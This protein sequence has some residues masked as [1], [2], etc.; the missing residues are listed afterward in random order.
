MVPDALRKRLWLGVGVAA[1]AAAAAATPFGSSVDAAGAAAAR[2]LAVTGMP[3]DTSGFS[4]S[5]GAE[6][7]GTSVAGR[8]SKAEAI[9]AVTR[10]GLRDVSPTYP[11]WKVLCG[12][13]AGTGSRTMVASISGLDNVGML[14]WA[15]FRWSGS[16]WQFLMKQRHAAVLTADASDIRETWSIYRESDSRCCPSGGT[17]SRIWHW[18]GNRF[19]ASP[20][21]QATPGTGTDPAG[22][23]GHFKSPSGNI[24]CEYFLDWENRNGGRQALIICAIRSGLKPKPPYTPQ[25]AAAGLDHN[26]DRINL[27]ATGRALPVVCSG[28]AGPFI[29]ERDARVL[30]YGKTWSGGGIRCTSAETGLTCRNK[31][32]HGFFLSRESWRRF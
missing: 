21:K 9:V 23:I 28:D 5:S 7:S 20:W 4:A 30:G 32:G 14:Y 3:E 6:S 1:V 22:Q 16:E 8:C 18:N 17:K 24:V 12:A 27:L 25:C 13:F 26:A 15:V 31:S 19:T 10:L 11:V 2:D 29:G